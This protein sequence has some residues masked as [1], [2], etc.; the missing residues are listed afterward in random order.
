[1]DIIFFYLIACIPLIIAGILWYSNKKV[2]FIEAIVLAG[3]GFIISGM[4]HYMAIKG[5]TD[6]VET[7]SGRITVA[8]KHSAWK[9]AYMKEIYRTEYY[10]VTETRTRSVKCGKGYTTQTYTVSVRKSKEVFSHLEPRTRWHS[11]TF[12]ATDS[13]VGTYSV[14]EGRY[15][16]ILSKFGSSQAF[17]GNRRNW[18][19]RERFNHMIE[20]DPNDYQTTNVKNYVYP[21]TTIRPWINKV[22][23]SPSVFSY[24]KVPQNI[25]PKLYEYPKNDNKFLSDRNVGAASWNIIELDQLNA[26]LGATKKVNVIAVNFGNGSDPNLAT[27]LESYW[28]GGKKNDLVICFGTNNP[29]NAITKPTWCHTFGWSEKELVKRNIDTLIIDHGVNSESLSLIEKE[30]EKNYEMKNWSKFDYLT[31]EIPSIYFF[32]CFVIQLAVIS[33]W[34]VIALYNDFDKES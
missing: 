1:M 26:R 21:V 15:E 25:I 33:I 16:D 17:P 19:Y 8:T 24:I 20:G 2:N 22:K 7:W 10:N 30:I 31:V 11:A 6:D 3:L 13:L 14:D 9:E 18:G 12:D 27:W 5:M 28:I 32:W 23:A 34:L 4:F 29:E